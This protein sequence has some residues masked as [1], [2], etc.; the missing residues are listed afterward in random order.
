MQLIPLSRPRVLPDFVACYAARIVEG[1]HR[2][3][4]AAGRECAWRAMN[5]V[6][7]EQSEHLLPRG[8]AGEPEWPPG[9]TGSITHTGDFVAAAAAL[10]TTV[11]GIG[12]DAEH[13]ASPERAAGVASSV[14]R[15]DER[16][17][18]ETSVS[19]PVKITLL[20]S[21]KEAVFKCLYPLV[22]K[23][24]YYP[25]VRV[26]E[27]NFG[28]GSF[29]AELVLPLPGFPAG[30]PLS[31]QFQVDETRVHAGIWLPACHPA[32]YPGSHL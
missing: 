9:L 24:F 11:R 19:L 29:R 27:L 8:P 17:L 10:S 25:A 20:F 13:I 16:S 28:T 12:L 6:M 5:Q 3:H 14:M 18:A 26:I 7:G 4:F 30:Y 23:R 31:G 21:I 2:M 1:D 22:R 32:T 15:P